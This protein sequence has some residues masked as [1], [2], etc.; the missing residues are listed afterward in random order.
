VDSKY[1]GAEWLGR[2][3]DK[4]F[5]NA[6]YKLK[7]EKSVHIGGSG[8]HTLVLNGPLFK[9]RLEIQKSRKIWKR[10]YG[11]LEIDELDLVA[12]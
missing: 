5:L 6:V 1:F 8:Y 11:V 10:G 2:K 3:I 4:D 9:K 12:K 7:R